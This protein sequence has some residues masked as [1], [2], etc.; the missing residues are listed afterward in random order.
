MLP[1][2]SL[3]AAFAAGLLSITSPC[4]FPLIP[5]YLAHLAGVSDPNEGRANRTR[6]LVNAFA[7]VLGFSAIFVA[8]GASIGAAGG[9]VGTNREWITRIGGVFMLIMGLHLIGV[10][11]FGVL[12]R[13]YRFDV[14]GGAGGKVASSFVVGAAF[15]AGWTPCVGPILG[16]IL[17][18]AAGQSDGTQAATLLAVY[19]AG[20]GIPFLMA[21]AAFGS[22]PAL[23]RRINQRVELL[24]TVGEV[25]IIAAGAVLLLGIYEPIFAEIARAAPWRPLEPNL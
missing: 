21:A 9:L 18:M 23:I 25:V 7:F 20:M 14:A 22:A 1:Q 5:V 6:V 2:I 4:V 15:G 8:L 3:I 10:L 19:A 17:T 24:H 11:K 13:E 16:T 12:Q